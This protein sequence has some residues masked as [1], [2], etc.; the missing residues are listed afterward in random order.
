MKRIIE[1]A[2]YNTDTATLIAS[3]SDRGDDKDVQTCLY[4]N[5]AGMYFAIDNITM[6]FRDREGTQQERD[7]Y[8]WIIV[9][10]AAD[11]RDFC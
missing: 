9:R 11:A 6:S 8:E 10:N 2:T 3:G 7:E 1:G 5:G 4:Q